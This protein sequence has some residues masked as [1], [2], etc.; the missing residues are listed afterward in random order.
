[1]ESVAM[2]DHGTLSGTIEFYKRVQEKGIKPI[3]GIETYVAS[4][5]AYR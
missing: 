3:V 1:M 4:R 5:K 2:T